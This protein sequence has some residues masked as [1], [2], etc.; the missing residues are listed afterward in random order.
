MKNVI[1]FLL[2]LFVFV[3]SVNVEGANLLTNKQKL[4]EIKLEMET[5]GNVPTVEVMIN[6]KKRLFYFDSGGGIS[7]ISPELANE[8]GCKQQSI[9]TGYNA[10]G[11]KFDTNLCEDVEL[12]LNGYKV[13]RDIGVFDPNE[14][15]PKSRAKLDGSV[16]LDTFDNQTITMDF[17]GNRI[18]VENKKSFKN[19]I[20]D[21]KPLMSRL[22]REGGGATLDFFVAAQTPKGKIWMLVD[23][24]NTNK[25]L[26]RKQAQQQLGISLYN[27][28]GEKIQKNVKLDLIGYGAVEAD[29]LPRDMIYDGMLNYEIIKNILWSV[30]LQ[31]GKVWAKQNK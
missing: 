21:M 1:I 25:L 30:D 17:V 4:I 10:G 6:G 2:F 11:M 28:K 29:A 22:S 15:F 18:W 5:L 14:Y 8:I 23:T 20:K 24:G 19:R 13:K 7:G 31:T 16:A 26:F 3:E 9:T 12:D 27:E